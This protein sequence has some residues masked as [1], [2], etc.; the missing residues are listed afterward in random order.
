ML[1]SALVDRPIRVNT[2]YIFITRLVIHAT[3]LLWLSYTLFLGFSG[4]LLGDPVQHLLDFTGIAT[5]N[6]LLLSLCVS[7]AAK[8]LKFAQ[9]IGLRKTLGVYSAVYA[10]AHFSVFIAFELQFEWTLIVSEIIERPYITVGFAALLI[11]IALL[12]TSLE[13]VKRQMGKSWGRL[14]RW[15]YI[16][17]VLGLLH[18]LWSI[19]ASELTPYIYIV[20]GIILLIL[21]KQKIKNFFK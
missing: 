14:H 11:L 16:A 6:L 2:K 12:L 1:K 20:L 4:G 10:L 15:V 13:A 19:K 8:S 5:L 17:L 21:R 9:L 18:F 7:P 3:S